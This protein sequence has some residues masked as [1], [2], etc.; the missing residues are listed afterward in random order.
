LR[1]SK[2]AVGHLTTLALSERSLV[3]I[4]QAIISL[5]MPWPRMPV[6]NSGFWRCRC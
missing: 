5:E 2:F 6:L 1:V 4:D 3:K